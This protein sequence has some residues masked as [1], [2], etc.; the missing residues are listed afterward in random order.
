MSSVETQCWVYK[1]DCIKDET[2]IDIFV[3]NTKKIPKNALSYK[4]SCPSSKGTY[5]THQ[6]LMWHIGRECHTK[7][8]L[9][10]NKPPPPPPS[11]PSPPSSPPPPQTV[12]SLPPPPPSS[13][14]PQNFSPKPSV[15]VGASIFVPV[16]E[17]EPEVPVG[18]MGVEES[19]EDPEDC[20]SEYFLEEGGENQRFDDMEREMNKLKKRLDILEKSRGKFALEI[21]LTFITANFLAKVFK[22]WLE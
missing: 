19:V 15:A 10:Q 5:N 21:L 1:P 17:K 8:I 2:G 6:R 14:E 20:D 13:P 9:Q 4:C 11:S 16:A 7:W 12:S 3:D 18:E 22:T